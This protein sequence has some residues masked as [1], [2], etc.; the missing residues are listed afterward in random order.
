MRK[1]TVK[2]LRD[3]PM[4]GFPVD[5][6]ERD[7]SPRL[8]MPYSLFSAGDI[9]KGDA[10]PRSARF[11]GGQYLRR[12]LGTAIGATSRHQLSMWC[13]R[14]LPG[15]IHTFMFAYLDD[16]NYEILRFNSNDQ[17]EYIVVGGGNVLVNVLTTRRF[18]DPSQHMHVYW[19]YDP[20]QGTASNRCKF[21]VNN[22]LCSTSG[23]YPGTSYTSWIG[24]GLY[25]G[26]VVS[27]L[28]GAGFANQGF[29]GYISRF[30]FLCNTINGGPSQFGRVSA[31]TGQWVPKNYAG[32]YASTSYSLR[33]ASI[34]TASDFGTDSS[35][36]AWNFTVNGLSATSGSLYDWSYDVPACNYCT[37][38][39]IHMTGLSATGA[40][41]AGCNAVYDR[42]TY[43][44]FIGST[45]T[46]PARGKWYFEFQQTYSNSTGLPYAT[47]GI[48]DANSV[49]QNQLPL[50]MRCVTPATATKN[51]GS[52]T[53]YGVTGALNDV[54][55]CA[56]DMDS[57]KI[58]FSRNGVWLNSGDPVSGANP[59]W[60]DLVSS[61]I[62]WM[63]G[64]VAIGDI[65]ANTWVNFGQRAFANTPPSGYNQLHMKNMSDPS[66]LKPANGASLNL[67]T[68]T[69][70]AFSVSGRLFAPNLVWTKA[71][72][73]ATSWALYDSV[74]G[75]QNEISTDSTAVES[76]QA[77]GVTAFNSGGFSGGTLAKINNNGTKFLDIMLRRG[78]AYGVDIVTY[79]G[80]GSNRTISHSLGKAPE[81]IIIKRRSGA[82]ASWPVWSK[83]N[84]AL[85]GSS[86][87]L[88]LNTT[89]ASGAAA[90]AFNSTAPTSSVFSVGTSA[91][92]NNNGDTYV[93][94]LFASVEG[95]LKVGMFAGNG[96]SNGPFVHCNFRPS[97]L[98]LKNVTSAGNS[99]VVL[100]NIRD[101]TN[102]AGTLSFPNDSA[103]EAPGHPFDWLSNG[104]KCRDTNSAVN[105]SSTNFIY[106]A[107]ADMSYKYANAR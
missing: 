100:D 71:R 57:G 48:I 9:D 30:D 106:L 22:V 81:L 7:S 12:Q 78:A 107:I 15:S 50:N 84:A 20:S 72:D 85:N 35:G 92:T 82:V 28:I 39:S 34:T 83:Q 41:N 62:T 18:R 58:F 95:F 91:D 86:H 36:N 76:V 104:F 60:S 16:N 8:I 65:S 3:M 29:E 96:A 101:E 5:A 44:G 38:S 45:M 19:E 24:G 6:C 87:V 88:Y 97:F 56:V 103:A 53:P 2:L 17:L 80:N 14:T 67:R 75:V 102:P 11:R 31:D 13:K 4:V 33:F 63:A 42:S 61:G 99:W 46:I 66:I 47:V 59:A 90:T 27:T 32:S 55:G 74:R 73:A 89:A 105:A 25:G 21:W 69:G 51:D 49:V 93:A 23:T 94:Y 43:N 77:Q 64:V 26:T 79:T 52:S 54:Y 40:N 68:G 10:M 98:M 70:S 37:L 1:H